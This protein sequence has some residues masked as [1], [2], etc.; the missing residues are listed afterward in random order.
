M[1]EWVHVN[2]LARASRPGYESR[3]FSRAAVD[4][5]IAEARGLDIKS[6]LC[7]LDHELQDYASGLRA[8][9]GLV[10]YYR[11]CRPTR[12]WLPT[13]QIL[14]VSPTLQRVGRSLRGRS[15]S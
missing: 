7:L 3:D 10:G 6:I 2:A 4:R 1:I 8:E 14:G 13:E 5:W 12:R 15:L 9:G 11:A